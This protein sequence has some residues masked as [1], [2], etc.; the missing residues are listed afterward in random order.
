GAGLER[1]GPVGD[2]RGVPGHGVWR[3]EIF[4]AEIGAIEFELHAHH[5]HVVSGR[6]R[7][8]DGVRNRRAPERRTDRDGG[9]RRIGRGGHE[10][11]RGTLPPSST[12]TWRRRRVTWGVS[13]PPRP[14]RRLPP[15]R[16]VRRSRARRFRTPSRSLPRP[17][18]TWGW[19]ACNSNSMAPI[20]ARKISWRHTPC[21]GTPRRSPTGPIRSR[22]APGMRPATPRPR[23]ASVWSWPTPTPRALPAPLRRLPP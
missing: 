19:W 15:S 2:R 9:R 6:G 14:I 22:P 23:P 11:P 21:P 13:W 4:R 12:I 16:S 18:T 3:H 17:L 5:P 10:T 1:M 20:S 8:R 7:D